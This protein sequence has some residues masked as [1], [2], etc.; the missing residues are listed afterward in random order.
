MAAGKKA[1]DMVIPDDQAAFLRALE[2][3]FLSDRSHPVSIQFRIYR[4]G[5]VVSATSW[6][7]TRI[8]GKEVEEPYMIGIGQ[9]VPEPQWKNEPR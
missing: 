1:L 4:P 5:Y 8:G 9:L 7:F 3:C 2:Q 6:E